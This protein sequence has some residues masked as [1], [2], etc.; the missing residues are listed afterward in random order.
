M[1]VRPADRTKVQLAQP[2]ATVIVSLQR[3][4]ERPAQPRLERVAR[5]GSDSPTGKRLPARWKRNLGEGDP[6]PRWW[7]ARRLSVKPCGALLNQH[8]A[9]VCPSVRLIGYLRNPPPPGGG[10]TWRRTPETRKQG[11]NREMTGGCVPQPGRVGRKPGRLARAWRV[12]GPT[13]PTGKGTGMVVT[14]SEEST[15]PTRMS[16]GEGPQGP[17]RK[18]PP[19]GSTSVGARSCKGHGEYRVPAN[20]RVD[21]HRKV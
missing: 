21:Q 9:G 16:R 12:E 3:K 2:G 4:A 5:G 13:G 18:A 1:G 19:D 8:G 15:N 10:R 7:A 11:Q 20:R 6:L 17:S 14:L